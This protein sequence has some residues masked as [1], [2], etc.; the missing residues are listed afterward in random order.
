MTEDEIAVLQ[1]LIEAARPFLD[2][3]IV[4]ETSGTIP[5][6]EELE[7]AIEEAQGL[8]YDAD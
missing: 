3:K 6:M 4:T 7:K 1:R 8:L 5:L 2:G